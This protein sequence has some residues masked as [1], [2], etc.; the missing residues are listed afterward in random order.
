MWTLYRDGRAIEGATV[1]QSFDGSNI[2]GF[3]LINILGSAHPGI[4]RANPLS[5]A[6]DIFPG[7]CF[8]VATGA[9]IHGRRIA[10]WQVIR[11]KACLG[12]Q[13]LLT[14]IIQ[15]R[16]KAVQEF[17]VRST[18]TVFVNSEKLGDSNL[19][20]VVDAIEAAL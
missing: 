3:E 12:N 15:G 9:E 16:N 2:L 19:K 7:F 6:P 14:Q 4:D 1:L 5:A 17:G 13:E 10:L 18:P 11:I 20:T 8:S